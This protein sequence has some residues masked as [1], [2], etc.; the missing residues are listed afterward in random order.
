MEARVW[1][2]A[3]FSLFFYTK[4]NSV[5]GD[6][7]SASCSGGRDADFLARPR[8]LIFPGALPAVGLGLPSPR[9]AGDL[10][11][12]LCSSGLSSASFLYQHFAR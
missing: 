6:F 7:G 3:F 2:M 4:M 11:S 12:S 9:A 10:S 5:L 8:E 1:K